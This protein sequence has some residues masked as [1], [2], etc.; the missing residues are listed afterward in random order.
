[1]TIFNSFLYVYQRVSRWYLWFLLPVFFR[2]RMVRFNWDDRITRPGAGRKKCFILKLLFIGIKLVVY[3][4][5][6]WCLYFGYII[7]IYLF[8]IIFYLHQLVLIF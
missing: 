8:I 4:Y 1:M 6:N 2:A 5:T 3:Q 7:Y